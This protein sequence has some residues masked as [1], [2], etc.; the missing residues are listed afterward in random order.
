MDLVQQVMR[1]VRATFGARRLRRRSRRPLAASAMVE[2]LEKRWMM[3]VNPLLVEP[4]DTIGAAQVVDVGAAPGG[5]LTLSGT[6]G[7]N[8]NFTGSNA[9]SDIDVIRLNLLANHRYEFDIDAATNGSNVDTVL[10]L[11]DSLDHSVARSDDTPAPGETLTTDSFIR[12]APTANG[13]YYL[14]VMSFAAN[15][16][17]NYDLNLKDFGAS[18]RVGP[19]YSVSVNAGTVFSG[20]TI[21]FGSVNQNE[22]GP[23][24]T[25]SILNTGDDA[26][27]FTGVT[28]PNASGQGYTVL[29]PPK[30][31]AV[32]PNET[33]DFTIALNTSVLGTAAGQIL[34]NTTALP[35]FSFNATGNVT[36]HPSGPE[37]SVSLGGNDYVLGVSPA[38]NFFAPAVDVINTA[39]PSKVF[40]IT[41][42]GDTTLTLGTPVVPTGFVI[43][44]GEGPASTVA[45][46]ASTTMTVHLNVATTASYSG[47]LTFTNND[48]NENPFVIPLTGNVAGTPIIQ[49]TGNGQTITNGDLTPSNTDG[50]SF[51]NVAST[52]TLT[53]T[54]TV[55]NIGGTGTLSLSGSPG[56][57]TVT[58][59]DTASFSIVNP[60]TDA[61][62]N[63]NGTTTF[64]VRFTP[65]HAGLS[66]ALITVTS[67]D[68]DNGFYTFKVSAHGLDAPSLQSVFDERA[69]LARYADIRNAVN[70]GAWS[71]G[72]AHFLAFGLQ[73]GRSP[74]PYFNEAYYLATNSD[75]AANTGAG[76]TW[77]TGFEHFAATG[78]GEGR[79]PNPYF[80]DAIYRRVNADIGAAVTAG[81]WRSGFSHYTKAGQ[82]EGRRFNL[83]YSEAFY[84][85]QNADV[86][87]NVGVGKAWQSGF[88][89]FLAFGLREG[90]KFSQLFDETSYRSLNPDVN[91]AVNNGAWASGFQ[92]Y[93][94]AGRSEGRRI[95]PLFVESYY[96]TKNPDVAAAVNAGNWPSGRAHFLAS[97]I[98]EGRRFS[99]YYNEAAYLAN[100]ADIAAN[101]G[102]GKAWSS[103]LEHYIVFGQF[104]NRVH[105][106][107]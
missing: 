78:Q 6:I 34:V 76:K 102:P 104:E 74:N 79:S 3:T 46:G 41:N 94:F 63:P 99:P 71:S 7:D 30:P 19:Q 47:N 107:A 106:V 5:Q 49:I 52:T 17:G 58:G 86:A 24:L 25:F 92:H 87:A 35:A 61:V 14:K 64:Q 65:T 90:R 98:N 82:F 23:R 13:T 54:F 105:A 9:G 10:Q 93:T 32:Q 103:G 83:F 39:G 67:N 43:L 88:Q 28:V 15:T 22:S 20:D 53:R 16:T 85:S 42:L 45:P 66:T 101:V 62:L 59:G 84:L 56:W 70:T 60:A 51:G 38:V 21:N 77:I 68:A 44:P 89:H 95:T 75:V 40:T 37:I 18:T 26:L 31:T 36:A 1:Q 57:A 11:V 29:Q 12:F 27:T 55:T 91:T 100:N 48:S 73:E 69:Y 8:P 96:L 2:T 33:T 81:N 4:N 97:G 72:F 80:S 50:T